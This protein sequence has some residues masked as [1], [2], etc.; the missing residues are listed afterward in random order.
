VRFFREQRLTNSDPSSQNVSG[1]PLT[2]PKNVRNL[3]FSSRTQ[4]SDH[5]V[6]NQVLGFFEFFRER[7][8]GEFYFQRLAKAFIGA[9]SENLKM[10]RLQPTGFAYNTHGLDGL[11][12][13]NV[14]FH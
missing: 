8:G 9:D 14:K 6:P 1:L 10:R 7:E 12:L 5:L 4:V 11:I 3:T 13:G 2:F